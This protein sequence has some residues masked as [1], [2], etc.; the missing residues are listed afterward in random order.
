MQKAAALRIMDANANRAREALRVLEDYARFALNHDELCAALKQFRHE[1]T[2]AVAPLLPE[3]I[4]YRD[5]PGDVGTDNKTASEGV[6]TGLAAVVTAAG[7]RLGEAMRVIEEVLK[8]EKPDA[9]TAVEKL[10]YRLYD[11]EQQIARTIRPGRFAAVRLYVL[12]TE[13]LC[14]RPWLQTAEEAILGGADCIQLREK[15]FEG[16]DLL[17]RASELVPLCR[18]HGVIC[19]VND[20]PDVA[21][22][23]G[24]DGVHLGQEDLPAADARKIV[25]PEMI[26]G[27]SAQTM[28]HARKAV[29]DGADYIGVGPIF[30]STTKSRPV[31][32]GPDF[33]RQVAGS[34]KIP[35]V[36]IAGITEANV[37]EVL[38]TGIGAIAVSSA[39]IAAEDVRE[40]A[41]RL[42][43]RVVRFVRRSKT[44]SGVIAP[45]DREL[46]KATRNLP[47][48][49]LEGSTYYVTFRTA[50]GELSEHE[51]GI[52]LSHVADGRD[53]YYTLIAIVVMPDHVHVVLRPDRGYDLSRIMKG[54][55]GASARKI[56]EHRKT[57]GH[58]WQD[59]SYDRIM[60]NE[61][62][63]NEKLKYML[64]NPV[65]RNLVGDGWDYPWW[66]LNE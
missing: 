54:V 63:L 11:L 25:G 35:A 5:T 32:P 23:S 30:S 29:L 49:R 2:A 38:A 57:T 26:I 15:E 4:L 36:A 21:V 50:S 9:A 6:R 18:R 37:D 8:I 44:N 45:A 33:A 60:R 27:V 66:L 65:K 14:K 55:K 3:A 52:V 20:R 13:S 16:A 22:L 10:R 56:N 39:V 24:A 61:A 43:E 53:K 19:V 42:K 1:L 51:R 7:K 62:E 40:A 64:E 28:E 34:I 41:R 59:E 58:V 17:R 48:W 12:V 47:R 31:I 46:K